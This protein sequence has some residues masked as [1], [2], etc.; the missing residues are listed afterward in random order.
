[1][2]EPAFRERSMERSEAKCLEK[3]RPSDLGFCGPEEIRTPDHTRASSAQGVYGDLQRCTP[4]A[5]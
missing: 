2:A 4:V 5:I 3:V 1:M